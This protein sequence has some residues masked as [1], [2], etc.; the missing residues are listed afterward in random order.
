MF[1]DP[2]KQSYPKT[3]K[4]MSVEFR[5]FFVYHVS[6][7]VLMMTGGTLSIQVELLIAGTLI[8]VLTLVSLQRRARMGWRWPGVSGKDLLGALF[9]VVLISFF[10]YAVTPLFPPWTPRMLPW[11]MAGFGIGLFGV[12]GSLR[13]VQTSESEFLKE[14]VEKDR[15]APV[16]APVASDAPKEAQWKRV[17]RNL[18]TIIFLSVWISGVAFFYYF[19][20]AFRDGSK[21][22]TATH[23]ERLENHG[24]VVYV[25][26]SQKQ[27]V[28]RLQIIMFAGLPAVI[29]GGFALHFLVGVKLYPGTP[30]LSEY[31]K[32]KETTR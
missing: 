31:R 25:P 14:C 28:D 22:I 18:Y 12:L 1:P 20:V 30:T 19:G 2:S 7:M 15:F 8:L 21:E 9:T 29:L 24:E 3:W 5:L 4:E 27:L 11:Y 17:M 26:A 6:M 16:E 13:L 10:L 23:T 32:R